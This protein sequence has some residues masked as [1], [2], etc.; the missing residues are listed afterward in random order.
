M[1]SVA[2]RS[3]RAHSPRFV[4]GDVDMGRKQHEAAIPQMLFVAAEEVPENLFR[5]DRG[6]VLD[7]AQH[8]RGQL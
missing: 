3:R 1:R 2:V 5:L 4:G 7:V 8:G 6:A